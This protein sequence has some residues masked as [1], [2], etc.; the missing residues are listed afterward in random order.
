MDN[1]K[2]KQMGRFLST[3]CNLIDSYPH[4]KYVG[5]GK[6]QEIQE[7]VNNDMALQHELEIIDADLLFVLHN[8][9]LENIEIAEERI[10]KYIQY[11]FWE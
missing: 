1:D 11:I 7:Q 8:G 10:N 9:N 2:C 3:P 5:I 6:N 4:N